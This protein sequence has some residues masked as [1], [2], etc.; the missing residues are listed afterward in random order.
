MMIY[1]FN[2]SLINFRSIIQPSSLGN[3]A[4]VIEDANKKNSEMRIAEGWWSGV[5]NLKN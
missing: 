4:V 2:R 5:I 3:I 1:L